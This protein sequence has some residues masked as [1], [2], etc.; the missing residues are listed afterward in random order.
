MTWSALGTADLYQAKAFLDAMRKKGICDNTL[1][2]YVAG[3]RGF[4]TECERSGISIR[5][6]FEMVK[7]PKSSRQPTR[8]ARAIS[9]PEVQTLLAQPDKRTARGKR[10]YAILCL[11]FGAGLRR[12]EVLSLKVKDFIQDYGFYKL[13]LYKTKTTAY[14]EVSLSEWVSSAVRE[15]KIGLDP[16]DRMF[17]LSESGINKIVSDY[18][19]RAGLK[20]ITPHSGRATGITTLLEKGAS[21]QSVQLFS[22]HATL[23]SIM[24]YDRRRKA[25][26]DNPGLTLDYHVPGK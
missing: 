15:W 25:L 13:R 16:E 23:G 9:P 18:A 4:Y 24:S 20:G 12:A 14:R 22:G 5:N 3:L 21:P 19:K 2:Y 17:P 8:P 1:G 10:D 7:L 26:A 11:F 6:P